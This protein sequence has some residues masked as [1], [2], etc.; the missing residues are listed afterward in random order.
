LEAF[1]EPDA[2]N[3]GGDILAVCTSKGVENSVPMRRVGNRHYRETVTFKENDVGV[4]EYG[5]A[6]PDIWNKVVYVSN[7]ARVGVAPDV[8]KQELILL[9]FPDTTHYAAVGLR[10]VLHLY[11]YDRKGKSYD[12]ASPGIGTTYRFEDE[13]LATV[14]EDGLL[15]AFAP[16]NT[17]LYASYQSLS[18]SVEVKLSQPTPL[19]P[20]AVTD[21]EGRPAVPTVISPLEGTV[22][23]RETKVI[24][25]V[26]S[27]D[28]SKGHRYGFSSWSIIDENG[29][30]RGYLRNESEK[31]TWIP[32]LSGR[33]KW[34]MM[35]SYSAPLTGGE[36]SPFG[37]K[38][39]SYYTPWTTLIVVPNS[40][41]V[42][43]RK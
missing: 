6:V 19:P 18:A 14:T 1:F 2:K 26:T 4:F 15:Q 16:G 22:V 20:L 41:D 30:E 40:Q 10:D 21:P 39:D 33:Y 5:V 31:G 29:H 37:E 28:V 13:S 8:D 32:P 38:D 36:G 27:F 3:L 34:R 24:F 9:K 7:K 23:E 42:K 12:L 43:R 11:A 17:M 25:E 35:Y